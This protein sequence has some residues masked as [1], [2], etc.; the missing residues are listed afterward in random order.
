MLIFLKIEEKKSSTTM[1]SFFFLD[2]YHNSS[3]T[4]PGPKRLHV[5]SP[6][7]KLHFQLLAELVHPFLCFEDVTRLLC[8]A[9][10]RGRPAVH[11][12][13]PLKDFTAFCASKWRV[14]SIDARLEATFAPSLVFPMFPGIERCVLR[15]SSISGTNAHLLYN[16][17]FSELPFLRASSFLSHMSIDD[18]KLLLSLTGVGCQESLKIFSVRKCPLLN[19]VQALN[20]CVR[21]EKA[22]FESCPRIQHWPTFGPSIKQLR[23]IDCVLDSFETNVS[24][25]VNLTHVCLNRVLGIETLQ[26]LVNCP[27]RSLVIRKCGVL[28]DISDLRSQK[29]LTE[30]HISQSHW[31]SDLSALA[32]LKN[33]TS[34]GLEWQSLVSDISAVSQIQSLTHCS[35]VG[36]MCCSDMT[37]LGSCF[38]L[39]HLDVSLTSI[40]DLQFLADCKELEC[41]TA[42]SARNLVNVDALASLPKLKR[43]VLQDCSR[44]SAL[45]TL[46]FNAS[47]CDLDCRG[48]AP[49]EACMEGF[50]KHAKVRG[51]WMFKNF[52]RGGFVMK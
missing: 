29:N 43:V 34:L 21:L 23:I 17:N 13:V 22:E 41:L 46:K 35:L 5:A 18:H 3:M 48:C 44:L 37:P 9:K 1:V 2:R 42:N 30:L 16:P 24:Q 36:L 7:S 47:I 38:K 50:E 15:C 20:A 49:S 8:S 6:T 51:L 26:G 4:E 31:V 12:R 28:K 45:G 10:F 39:R 40:V 14:A 11:I 32:E 25:S 52:R 27:L 19:N 33:L